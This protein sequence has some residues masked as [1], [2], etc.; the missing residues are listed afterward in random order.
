[1]GIT[2]G[3]IPKGRGWA[4]M[5]GTKSGEEKEYLFCH[6]IGSKCKQLKDKSNWLKFVDHKREKVKT[7]GICSHG[8]PSSFI[9]IVENVIYIYRLPCFTLFSF[10]NKERSQFGI[11]IKIK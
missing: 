5:K 8:T 10:Y 4:K 2:K 7:S 9:N 3:L 1:M 11:Q 6:G